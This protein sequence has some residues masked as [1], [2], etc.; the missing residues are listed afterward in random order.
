MEAAEVE[1]SVA[2]EDSTEME[3]STDAEDSVGLKAESNEDEGTALLTGE[4]ADEVVL[5]GKDGPV[6]E[7]GPDAALQ[8]R[9]ITVSNSRVGGS[10]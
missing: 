7:T 6:V 9:V 10:P 2:A 3:S 5:E 8:V 1:S 4:S